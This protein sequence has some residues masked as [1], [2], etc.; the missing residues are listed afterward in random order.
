[1]KHHDLHRPKQ[2][3]LG[4]KAICS[5]LFLSLFATSVYAQTFTAIGGDVVSDAFSTRSAS[6]GD[7]DGDG[8]LD[9]LITQDDDDNKIYRNDNNVFVEVTVPNDSAASGTWGDYDN[10]GDLD[11]FMVTRLGRNLLYENDG[12][13]SFTEVTTGTIVNEVIDSRA[14]SFI[15]YNS[16]GFL[17]LYVPNRSTG[18]F[19]FE[20]DGAG[21]FTKVL[22]GPHVAF[23]NQS[24][25]ANWADYDG[26]GD[27][28]VFVCNDG[29]GQTNQLFRNELVETG[30]ATF[31]EETGV[32]MATE[33]GISEAASWGDYDND[34]DMD[35]YVANDGDDNNALNYFYENNGDGTFTKITTGLPSTETGDSE[36]CS[37][38]DY[39]NDGDLDLFVINNDGENNVLYENSGAP[40]Y[41]FTKLSGANIVTDGGGSEGG[42]WGD[43]DNDGDLDLYVA[44]DDEANFFYQNDGNGNS[45][46]RIQLEGTVS[47]VNAIGARVRVKAAVDGVTP[48]WQYRQVVGQTSAKGQ[49]M[50]DAHF[51]LASAAKV[52][53][54]EVIWPSGLV[55]TITETNSNQI[56]NIVE[57]VEVPEVPQ[58]LVA[59][60]ISDTQIDLTW[61]Q[62]TDT[63]LR[64]RIYRG[65]VSGGPYTL[66]DSVDHPTT[67]FSDDE[68]TA[69]T[70]Y[71]YVISA[72]DADGESGQSTEASATTNGAPPAT[73]TGLSAIGV[74]EDQIDLS[75]TANTDDPTRYYIY[76]SEVSGGTFTLIDSVDHPT[77]TFSNTGL[78]GETTYYYT[79]SAVNGSG[80]SDQTDEVS[81]TTTGPVPNVPTGLSATAVSA[82]QINLNWTANTDDPT[83]YYVYRALINGGTFTL[84]DSV[85]HPG[86]S[87]SHTGLATSTTY[88]YKISAVNDIG[89]SAQSEQ[90]SA[91]TFGLPPATPTN[92]TATS[93]GP[94]QID[95]SW[96]AS[97]GSPI[98]YY[99]YRSTTSGGTFVIVD[100]VNHPTTSYSNTGLD[101]LTTYYYQVSANNAWGESVLS[102]EASATTD[103]S[104]PTTPTNPNATT[105]SFSQIDLSWTTSDEEPDRY[106]IYRS[107]F[108][109]NGYV[110]VDSVDH[111]TDFYN[112]TGLSILTTYYYRF[113]AV[114]E[115][116][117]SALSSVT[118][119]TTDGIAPSNPTNL[120]ATTISSSE[121]DLSWTASLNGPVRYY[122]YRS[123]V[124]G[125]TF[126]LV[127]SVDHPTTSY[128]ASGLTPSTTYFYKVSAVNDWGESGQSGE[129]SATTNGV[130]PPT[131]VGFA[132]TTASASQIDL[133]WTA[134][135][136][137][138][139]QYLIYR[140]LT[141]GSGFEVIDSVLFGEVSY[142]DTG[143]TK[144]TTYY[145]EIQ[146]A[147]EWGRSAR[148]AEV[149]AT[150]DG[151]APTVPR[152]VLASATSATE[153]NLSWQA[154]NEDP[155]S[156]EIYRSLTSGSG[157]TLLTTVNAPAVSFDDSGLNP[158]TTYYYY[159]VAVNAWGTSPQS[160]EASAETPP[161]GAP[162]APS[163]LS[164]EAISR[165]QIDISWT[166]SGN[167][168]DFYRIYR[169]LDATS[170]FVQIDSINS[171][172]VTYSNVGLDSSTTYH[173]RV[174][175]VN[176]VGESAP[177][178]IDSATTFGI[179]GTAQNLSAVTVSAS[180]IDLSWDSGSGD[181]DSYRIYRSLTSS[182][183]FSEVGEV[184]AATTTF[185]DSNLT[186][187][188]TYYYHV[189]SVNSFGESGA[190][191]EAS[192]MTDGLPPTVP[193]NVTAEA[194]LPNQVNLEW[195]A[196]SSNPERY[197]IYRSTTSGSG[198]AL[199]DS[200][201]HPFT[202]FGDIDVS[203][204]TTY[205]YAISAV[206][207][208]GQ[209]ARSSEASAT[210]P[211]VAP[212]SPDNMI[213]LA[214]SANQIDLSWDGSEQNPMTY[215]V[216]RSVTSGSGYSLVD[217]TTHPDTTY[218]DRLLTPS[219]VYYYQ[220]TA[221]NNWGES[222][223]SVEDSAETTNLGVPSAPTNLIATT[224]SV[225]Q[226]NL[227]WDVSLSGNPIRYL[228]YRSLTTAAIEEIGSQNFTLIDSVEH[229]L[230]IYSDTDLDSSTT[231][232][233]HV[234]ALN[235]A[236][237]SPQSN[238]ASA[239]TFGAPTIPTDLTATTFS[240]SQID[241]TWTASIGQATKYFIYRSLNSAGP[242]A[243]VDSIDFPATAYSDTG[244]AA[245]TTYYYEI[246]SSNQWGESDRSDQGEATTLGSGFPS[247]PGN[248]LAGTLSDDK[249][250]IS[251][252]A[253][254]SN[255]LQYKIYR[256]QTSDGDFIVIDSVA[257]PQTSYIDEDLTP[258]T[259]YYYRVSATNDFGESPFSNEAP[260]TTFGPP[261]TPQSISAEGTSISTINLTWTGSTG[262]PDFYR[263]YRA[264]MSA[265]EYTQIDSIAHPMT[266]YS[267][268]GLVEGTSY[269]YQ[270]S[271][272]N[273]WGESIISDEIQA[274]TLGE[275]I[276]PPSIAV[277][278]LIINPTTP[279]QGQAVNISVQI[280]GT[281]PAVTLIYGRGSNT[282]SG[283]ELAMQLNSGRYAASIPGS[284]ATADGL[285]FRIRA[286]NV[287]DSAWYV[288]EDGFHNIN[289]AIAN[290]SPVTNIGAHVSGI[291]E[292]SW[293]TVALPF[294]TSEAVSLSDLFGAQVRNTSNEPT[295]WAAYEY[296]SGALRE[297]TNIRSGRGYFVYHTS[298]GGK[299]LSVTTAQTNN[300][301]AF[302]GITLN[303]GWNLVQW[304]FS[305]ATEIVIEDSAAIGSIWYQ[306]GGTWQKLT[307]RLTPEDPLSDALPFMGLA[308]FN[309]TSSSVSLGAVARL[310]SESGAPKTS[311]QQK[312]ITDWLMPFSI[313]TE[314]GVD[315]FN[316]IG[317][318]AS[319]SD[320]RDYLDEANPL[321]IGSAA[322]LYFLI[323]DNE[324][325]GFASDIRGMEGDGQVWDMVVETPDKASEATL[326]WDVPE[327]LPRDWDVAMIDVSRNETLMLSGVDRVYDYRINGLERSRFKIVA[328]TA[329]FVNVKMEE[330]L[331]SLP[332]SFALHQNYPNP[333]NATTRIRFELPQSG[334]I[335]IR[336]YNLLGQ[337]VYLLTN[338]IY[339]TGRHEI[340]WQGVDRSGTTVASGIYF[341]RMKSEG[342]V[343]TR[344]IML[345]K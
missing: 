32:V 239:T 270:L 152:N 241:L 177:S 198:F 307:D 317:V 128:S 331:A 103:G 280:A 196:S 142:S 214:V 99:I 203:P 110:V 297:V 15:D 221:V 81:A 90:V 227:G 296:S 134:N 112:D 168:P 224:G 160:S 114:N 258:S 187:L 60:T 265:G 38:A 40:N 122:I 157:F 219:T 147:N 132:A 104:P 4:I 62:N 47:N 281:N 193:A 287:A 29:G 222:A 225:S 299:R 73:P 334:R 2:N 120:T 137:A 231:Y 252:D 260:G 341:V 229:P 18:N 330:I 210:T 7:F 327:S 22:T 212:T 54:V 121:I 206:N 235:V 274:T 223:P 217:S 59:T 316:T 345:V 172:D 94:S 319:A 144:L 135:D 291:P 264:A 195:D 126:A 61:D 92:L 130:A 19:L 166:A 5:V 320:D 237:E 189:R 294:T 186:Q 140:S 204:E 162:T 149:N 209:S 232:Y 72:V 261:Q 45:W 226:I 10:D 69:S 343:K 174:A 138:T 88:Y 154:S 96:T 253:S 268:T 46:M 249:I 84:I 83:R 247:A 335:D 85:D 184:D 183:G 244:L 14:P 228:I 191:D 250:V 75:W 82:S 50:L 109:G 16:D 178:N 324:Q 6:W 275:T 57:G 305:F 20:G 8:D 242:F 158:L 33:G 9:L 309:Q 35:L 342:F 338:D 278:S 3:S 124:S 205:F 155:E 269:Y 36:D 67:T 150:T 23:G 48:T 141:S 303:P 108:A 43:Y 100:S 159:V 298:G 180:K 117:E 194:L 329:E 89:E 336:I 323:D 306:D 133:S 95:L 266:I 79:I 304:P 106:Y 31:V 202:S 238:E 136:A 30:S 125:G 123:L 97:T 76:R 213:A 179:A 233:Y 339:D 326:A 58:N 11:F 282:A 78:S 93:A 111:P 118:S 39:D 173:Y 53:S 273:E 321:T 290:F 86:V 127:D 240:S 181:I 279:S 236:G 340:E 171:P 302:S 28:D 70:T 310:A 17:D 301:E 300:V 255:P 131:P 139:D 200:V 49:N 185:A 52:D 151:I 56:L 163:D 116:G 293:N 271:A 254:A 113:S 288:S 284:E 277:E 197:Y 107:L 64:Y 199:I 220:V 192:A 313:Q 65:D 311:R 148:S 156:Y 24:L 308:I 211:G 332:G 333:F 318:A 129:S 165:T 42:A 71:Y 272:V 170:G 216:Y 105:I 146:A 21:N 218:S 207:V 276:L 25:A 161:I 119:A 295:N 169:S 145:Y 263:I 68:L 66:V 328:G 246:S 55:S 87:Y 115:W 176:A 143:L 27:M 175:A 41:T 102:D 215:R 80:E 292:G 251:W 315:R 289:V 167:G 74:A 312:K 344:K 44:N 262:N 37:W 243:V 325:R 101:D 34:G 285:W 230:N 234:R 190:S 91:T 286:I 314:T 51:G 77:V 256:R 248:L 208:W 153:I 257:H 188:T 245:S 259:V 201:V 283:T 12:T 98:E 26:D 1:M 322:D 13:G 164:A 182:N 267:D 63:P 337:E